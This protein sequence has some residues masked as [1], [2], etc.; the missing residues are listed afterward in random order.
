[1]MIDT[2][3]TPPEMPPRMRQLQKDK[4]G[5]PIPWFVPQVDG[6][7]DFR[8]TDMQKI[9][10]AIKGELCFICGQKLNRV[11]NSHAP[12][13][14]FVAGPMCLINRTSAEPPNH[15]DCAEWSSKACPFLTKPMKVRRTSDMPEEVAE[16]AGVMIERNPGVT[17]LIE[18]ERWSYFKVPDGM[19][20]QGIL[21]NFDR[22][23]TVRWMAE[24]WAA[25]T[26]QVLTS[27]ETGLPQLIEISADEPGALRALAMKTRGALRWLP[28][29]DTAEYPVIGDLLRHLP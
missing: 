8:F 9:V 14:T 18:S 26:D 3:R 4:V 13:G 21:F 28:S 2:V 12:K 16:P 15:T 1:M 25:S 7:Y 24:G 20:G 23:T 6:E 29:F 17:A 5:R 19:G 22:I 10:L 11:K 27:I